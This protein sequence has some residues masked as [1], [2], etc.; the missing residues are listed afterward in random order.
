MRRGNA[1]DC[2]CLFVCPVP[3]LTCES[4]DQETLFL[5]PGTF[6]DYLGQVCH[7]FKV[8]V[9]GAKRLYERK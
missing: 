6:S 7:R 8:K 1:L 5:V 4:R 3:A 2:I 9:T